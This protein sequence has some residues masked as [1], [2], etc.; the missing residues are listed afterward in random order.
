MLNIHSSETT[1]SLP[2]PA[3]SGPPAGAAAAEP[4]LVLLAVAA[5]LKPAGGWLEAGV[6]SRQ[7]GQ[8]KKEQAAR[9]GALRALASL[10]STLPAPLLTDLLKARLAQRLLASENAAELERLAKIIERL[11]EDESDGGRSGP[12]QRNGK[13]EAYPTKHGASTSS[14]GA[15]DPDAD[16]DAMELTEALA[17][18]KRLIDQLEEAPHG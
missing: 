14:T 7:L 5:G 16:V 2:P 17:E 4:E 8:L 10:G 3:G 9:L 18:A 1:A 6:T 15:P 11:P 12:P 13:L